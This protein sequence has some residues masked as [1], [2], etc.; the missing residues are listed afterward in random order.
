MRRKQIALFEGL[1]NLYGDAVRGSARPDD[2]AIR[3]TGDARFRA[4]VKESGLA[5]LSPCG[6]SLSLGV[7]FALDAFFQLN[8]PDGGSPSRRDRG[9]ESGIVSATHGE[10]EL[11]DTVKALRNTVRKLKQE[12]QDAI[13]S[14][15]RSSLSTDMHRRHRAEP[16][17]ARPFDLGSELQQ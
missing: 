16:F 13:A 15:G 10:S 17:G 2:A 12:G 11:E 9:F 1:V 14:T 3:C 5:L 7:G 8:R 6:P 4:P